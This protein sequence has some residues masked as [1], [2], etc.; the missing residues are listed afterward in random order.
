[1]A[2]RPSSTERKPTC[3]SCSLTVIQGYWKTIKQ[4]EKTGGRW[5]HAKC[6]EGGFRDDDTILLVNQASKNPREDI[7]ADM[8]MK[9]PK[10]HRPMFADEDDNV[11]DASMTPAS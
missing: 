4:N 11:G 3:A 8:G 2:P 10:N 6:V 9:A 5:A 7:L 1:M